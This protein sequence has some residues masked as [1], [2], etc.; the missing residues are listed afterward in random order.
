MICLQISIFEL[1]NTTSWCCKTREHLLWFA[2]K[3]V[4]LNYWIQQFKKPPKFIIVVICLQI[5]IF[6]LLN[7]TVIN[8]Q[9]WT[10]MLWFA[11]KLV[12]LNYWIQL[13]LKSNSLDIVVICL[14]ISIFELL[15]TTSQRKANQ[16]NLLWFAYKLVSLNYW[17]QHL[18]VGIPLLVGCDL[19]TN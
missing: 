8:S 5:S 17:I 1:L 18:H 19:L 9:R 14:Q 10:I 6:E 4:S 16:M 11:Y 2:Y 13:S 15:N 12:S 7:T 3:L